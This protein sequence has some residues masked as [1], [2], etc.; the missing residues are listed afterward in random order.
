[1]LSNMSGEGAILGFLRA[2]NRHQSGVYK[3][4][5]VKPGKTGVEHWTRDKTLVGTERQ[6][7]RR[8]ELRQTDLTNIRSQREESKQRLH[9]RITATLLSGKSFKSDGLATMYWAKST[10]VRAME[11]GKSRVSTEPVPR[12]G[13]GMSLKASKES[14]ERNRT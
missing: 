11:V 8:V 1:M 6:G 4:E 14:S 3:E 2:D 5:V 9:S 10:E 7:L 12:N 13:K